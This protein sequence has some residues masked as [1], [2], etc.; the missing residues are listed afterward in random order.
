[1]ALLADSLGLVGG[2]IRSGFSDFHTLQAPLVHHILSL[3]LKPGYQV[4]RNI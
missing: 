4:I 2:K 1:M 3:C